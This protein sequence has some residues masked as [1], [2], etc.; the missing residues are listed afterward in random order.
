VRSLISIMADHYDYYHNTAA[1]YDEY[2]EWSTG[3][4]QLSHTHRYVLAAVCPCQYVYELSGGTRAID[5]PMSACFYAS[6]S[7][8]VTAP[9]VIC[10]DQHITRTLDGAL[11]DHSLSTE[12]GGSFFSWLGYGDASHRGQT[13]WA[14][15]GSGYD[16]QPDD[17]ENWW[18]MR[19]C[20]FY[21][22]DWLKAACCSCHGVGP[23]APRM[24]LWLA[25]CA[26]AVYPIAVYPWA[27]IM[28]R[29][30]VSEYTLREPI[31]ETCL[32]TACCLPCS[33]VQMQTQRQYARPAAN[34]ERV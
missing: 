23:H 13:H 24:P 18:P 2:N 1:S 12:G 30:I 4:L 34:D 15:D 11:F 22:W 5:D 32:I 17:S 14:H 25:C 33:F 6:L 28:R 20:A 26:G 10:A 3:L 8:C 27:F 19:M 16:L 21:A 29:V 7:V 31:H 9:V